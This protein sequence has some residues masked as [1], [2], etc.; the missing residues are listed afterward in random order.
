M[1]ENVLAQ[2]K[3]TRNEKSAVPTNVGE[4][5]AVTDWN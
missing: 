5:V 3:E 2:C 1:K 4:L